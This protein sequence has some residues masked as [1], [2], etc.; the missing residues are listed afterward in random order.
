MSVYVD[1]GKNL[2]GRMIMCHMLADSREELDVMADQIGVQRKWIQFPGTWKEHYDICKSKKQ[3]AVQLGAI[4]IGS[5]EFVKKMI[6]R[7][8]NLLVYEFFF[9]LEHHA[10]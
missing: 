2:F 10:N 3:L 9:H 8:N 1:D 7:R 6:T 4:E 5:R